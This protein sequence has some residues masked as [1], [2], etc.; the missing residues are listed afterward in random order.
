MMS[1]CVLCDW[2]FSSFASMMCTYRRRDTTPLHWTA[3]GPRPVALFDYIV[4][5][6]KAVATVTHW[7]Q[8]HPTQLEL[9][10]GE[11]FELD[12]YPRMNHAT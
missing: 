1:D 8:A 7:A 11:P 3:D 6:A 5:T 9:A 10:L 2:E 4:E 12:S